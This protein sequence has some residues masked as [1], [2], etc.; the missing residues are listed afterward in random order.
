MIYQKSITTPKDTPVLTPVSEVM[1]VNK[2]LIYQVDIIIPAGCVGLAGVRL[3]DGLY[4]VY[5]TT[6]NTWFVGDNIHMSFQDTYL[7][8]DVPHQ[9]TVQTYNLDDTYEHTLTVIISMVIK[10]IFM[11]RFLPSYSMD[12]MI[13]AIELLTKVQDIDKQQVIEDAIS[14]AREN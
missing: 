2:G 10:E 12:E 5:P 7:K 1:E 9:L 14:W 13:K 11:A 8:T 6:P 3:L 4:Q